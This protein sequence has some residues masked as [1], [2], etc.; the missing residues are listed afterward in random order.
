M[1][2]DGIRGPIG[3]PS[4]R[5]ESRRIVLARGEDTIDL[6]IEGTP[7]VGLGAR[8]SGSE[9]N[10][11]DGDRATRHKVKLTSYSDSQRSEPWTFT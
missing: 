2:D 8:H 10:H 11:D 7:A 4:R 1:L 3:Q 9:K 6:R 5:P